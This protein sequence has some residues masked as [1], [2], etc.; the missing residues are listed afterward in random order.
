MGKHEE[1]TLGLRAFL[2]MQPARDC[3]FIVEICTFTYLVHLFSASRTSTSSK[4]LNHFRTRTII[5]GQ[6]LGNT[7]LLWGY[8]MNEQRRSFSQRPSTG[9]KV[10]DQD[11]RDVLRH[12]S[13]NHWPCSYRLSEGSNFPSNKSRFRPPLTLR[14]YR[15]PVVSLD[16]GVNNR[17]MAYSCKH[18]NSCTQTSSGTP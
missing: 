5:A 9:M 13:E 12:Q 7:S 11:P 3:A 8:Y 4:S 17:R 14:G 10:Y 1:K 15:G 2:G 16:G 6:H 18:N